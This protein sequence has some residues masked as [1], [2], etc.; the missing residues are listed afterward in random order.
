MDEHFI[1]IVDKALR[2]LLDDD[3]I[4]QMAQRLLF[5]LPDY[6]DAGRY[7]DG[8]I[9]WNSAGVMLEPHDGPMGS[10]LLVMFMHGF[11][12]WGD[13]R[14]REERAMFEELGISPEK[15][16]RM[17]YKGVEAWLRDTMGDPS[18]T[19]AMNAFLAK[20]PE[21]NA[22]TEAHCRAA[23]EAAEKLLQRDDARCL[24]LASTDVQPWL[25]VLDRRARETPEI[26]AALSEGVPH[27]EAIAS[28]FAKLV[29]EVASNTAKSVFTPERLDR[30]RA[31]L[32]EMR[33]GLSAEKN[34]E[35]LAG[36]HGALIAAQD[37]TAPEDQ[38]FLVAICWASLLDALKA[39]E[40][41][42]TNDLDV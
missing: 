41:H 38:H 32:H 30:L 3:Q 18:K 5:S 19:A 2:F 6:V 21:L 40:T 13:H 23:G 16:R 7:L 42:S 8:W 10:F 15:I 24:L 28:A 14:D 36:V 35:Q 39:L 31:Q 33:R 17:G 4:K 27:D 34:K 1:R 29:H 11:K 26:S 37:T 22:A 25:N 12:Q 20:H 9:I